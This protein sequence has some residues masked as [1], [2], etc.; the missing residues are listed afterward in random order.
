MGRPKRR[1][2][3]KVVNHVNRNLESL[4]ITMAIEVVKT[5]NPP[6]E[7]EHGKRGRPPHESRV[8]AVCCIL[9]IVLNKTY[10]GIEA[11]LRE[12]PRVKRRL[13]VS[14]IPTHSVIHRGMQQ[15]PLNYIRLVM[16]FVTLKYRRVGIN[17]AVDS[18]GMALSTSS[19]WF[20]IRI[21][22]KSSKKDYLKLHII[23]DL[24]NGIILHFT[25]TGSARH[26]SPEF[27]RLIR[28]LK[29]LAKV[30]G[31]AAYSSRKNCKLVA[32]KGG[33][34]YLKFKSNATGRASGSTEWKVSFSEYSTDNDAWMA[35][36]HLRS[37]IESIF[38]SLKR[39]WG[40][41]LRGK[42][43]WMRRREMALKVLAYDMK[44]VHYL[45]RA[46]ELGVSLW[47]PVSG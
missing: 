27:R 41:A 7:Q 42:R 5:L 4:S 38:G 21:R 19:K 14:S 20:D 37:I 10:D 8:V 18:S 39:R 13:H 36:Y 1:A 26:D 43:G 47:Q 33:K 15:L 17:A 11:Y 31:D 40:P 16:K 3:P 45:E 6:W 12:N 22:R 35:I 23:A 9:M 32:S 46:Q 34:P 2:S 30:L 25:I 24:D 44:Q 29:H 28:P